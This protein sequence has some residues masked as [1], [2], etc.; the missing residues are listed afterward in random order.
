VKKAIPLCIA[1]GLAF[2]PLP[3]QAEEHSAAL[4]QSRFASTPAAGTA[5]A[6]S[7]PLALSAAD[8]GDMSGGASPNNMA[9]SSQTVTAVNS[10]NSI[11]G[12]SIV[13]G[14]VNLQSGAFNGFTGVGNFVFNTGN[15]NNLQGTLSVTILTPSAN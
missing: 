12:D 14:N 8:L 15:N 9:I 1:A 5:T 13:T 10:G 6:P 7:L 3:G 2:S 4:A 11:N